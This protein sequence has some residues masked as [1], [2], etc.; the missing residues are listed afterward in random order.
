MSTTV[1]RKVCARFPSFLLRAVTPLRGSADPATNLQI[2]GFQ[3]GVL[4]QNH[5]KSLT[6]DSF[7]AGEWIAKL[8][9]EKRPTSRNDLSIST[10]RICCKLQYIFAR[11]A[12]M[13][14]KLQY[15]CDL[16]NHSFFEVRPSINSFFRGLRF[17]RFLQNG[18]AY[19]TVGLQGSRQ[20]RFAAIYNTFAPRIGILLLFATLSRPGSHFCYY[21]QHFRALDRI[22]ATIY[23][24][25]AP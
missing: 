14:C 25:F 2:D 3:G 20:R 19:S 10:L 16:E 21:L 8:F 4:Q 1:I 11:G 24:T 9:D 13:H 15:I 5:R 7:Q 12:Q 22:F 17:L 18:I 23:N 6:I